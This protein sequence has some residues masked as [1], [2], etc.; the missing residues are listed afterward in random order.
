MI[1]SW[2]TLTTVLSTRFGVGSDW[3]SKK[4]IGYVA[5]MGQAQHNVL[6]REEIVTVYQRKDLLN[7]NFDRN[8]TLAPSSVSE[9]YCYSKMEDLTLATRNDLASNI[10]L[11]YILHFCSKQMHKIVGKIV[12]WLWSNCLP[13][14]FSPL[15]RPNLYPR[16]RNV[17][18]TAALS[19]GR[20]T[21]PESSSRP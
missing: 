15:I 21:L 9:N 14:Y 1:G 7:N 2:L 11:W 5:V 17:G 20:T 12:I 18:I 6:L 16:V 13:Q 3:S 4:S 10:L 19:E 8:S